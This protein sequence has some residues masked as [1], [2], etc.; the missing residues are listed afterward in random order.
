M[1]VRTITV[2]FSLLQPREEFISRLL[3]MLKSQPSDNLADTTS[4][5]EDFD[6]WEDRLSD[7]VTYL[8]ADTRKIKMIVKFMSL[9]FHVLYYLKLDC[10]VTFVCLLMRKL[11]SYFGR[12]LLS[13]SQLTEFQFYHYTV[14]RVLLTSVMVKLVFCNGLYSDFYIYVCC[15]MVK[16]GKGAYSC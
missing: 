13:G 16:K 2:I 12:C 7:E 11:L 8:F 3:S 5:M 14:S 1:I 15:F 6:S 10:F 4:S 9:I